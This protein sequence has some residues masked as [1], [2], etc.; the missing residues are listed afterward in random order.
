MSGDVTD[1]GKFIM[2]LPEKKNYADSKDRCESQEITSA[3]SF[4]DYHCR[5]QCHE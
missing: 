4:S 3:N 1:T 2:T 5:M